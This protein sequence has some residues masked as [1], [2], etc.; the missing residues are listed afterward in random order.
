MSLSKD[1]L[2]IGG[3]RAIANILVASNGA[4]TLNGKSSGLRT[5]EDAQRFHMI[6][7]L[8]KAV[9]IGGN[10]YRSEPYNKSPIPVFVSSKTLAETSTSKLNI[11][12]ATP[13][14]LLQAA[15]NQVGSPVI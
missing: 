15:L 6:R 8:A 4:T 11:K 12:N 2:G 5:L 13:I 9:L 3:A 7:K 10:T 14:K 1:G